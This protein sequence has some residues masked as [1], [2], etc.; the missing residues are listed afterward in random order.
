MP[1]TATAEKANP[2]YDRF[3]TREQAAYIERAISGGYM[4]RNDYPP[5]AL[6]SFEDRP[7]YHQYVQRVLADLTIK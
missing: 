4:A 1:K 3:L 5:F 7:R 6:V 2:N